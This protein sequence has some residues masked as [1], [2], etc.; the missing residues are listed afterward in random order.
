MI[1][2]CEVYRGRQPSQPDIQE[3]SLLPRFATSDSSSYPLNM[4]DSSSPFEHAY[5]RRGRHQA[6]SPSQSCLSIGILRLCHKDTI[7]FGRG[8]RVLR[9]ASQQ[10]QGSCLISPPLAQPTAARFLSVAGIRL[11]MAIPSHSHFTVTRTW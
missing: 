10:V 6:S 5:N 4:N 3:K 8:D 9:Y 2:N 7:K 1:N 11:F